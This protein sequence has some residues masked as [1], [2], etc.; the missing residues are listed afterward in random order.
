VSNGTSSQLS[1]SQLPEFY[2]AHSG[3]AIAGVTPRTLRLF[4]PKPDAIVYGHQGKRYGLFRRETL[5]AY[6][7]KRTARLSGGAE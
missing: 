7:A 1:P 2:S 3:A 4:G 6:A 5:E